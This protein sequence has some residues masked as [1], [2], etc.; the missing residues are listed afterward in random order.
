MSETTKVVITTP[1]TK[2]TI[3]TTGAP[4]TVTHDEDTTAND[5]A[6]ES[7]VN[8]WNAAIEAHGFPFPRASRATTAAGRRKRVA[9]WSGF[10]AAHEDPL[11]SLEQGL[12]HIDDW[13]PADGKGKGWFNV[14]WVVD[15]AEKFSAK[16]TDT[17]NLEDG[18]AGF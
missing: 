9:F 2:I 7:L 13:K 18:E 8:A 16:C 6:E 1:E 10:C 5:Q 14:Q 12:R 4:A 3:E 15:N 17:P 11:V